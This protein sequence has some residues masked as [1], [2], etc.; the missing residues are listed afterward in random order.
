MTV[1]SSAS[2][3]DDGHL[4]QARHPGRAPTPLA[5]NDL[6]ESAAACADGQR[7]Q[8]AV[9][10][11]G[12]RQSLQLL[13]VKRAAGLIR[14]RLHLLQRQLRHRA[15]LGFFLKIAGSARQA[16]RPSPR[17]F[18][19]ISFRPFLRIS[20]AT[21]DRPP[22]RGSLVIGNDRQAVARGLGETDIAGMA[23]A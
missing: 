16:P 14:I 19:L 3:H 9:G 10:G 21:A 12:I 20:S 13:L 23:L 17:C 1:R 4:A 8:D 22:H 5:R 6:I 11:N 2:E 15:A 18:A 7:L